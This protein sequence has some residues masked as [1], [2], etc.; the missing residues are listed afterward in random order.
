MLRIKQ[1]GRF[2]GSLNQ[3][4]PG[5]T[6]NDNWMP[7]FATMYNAEKVWN[8]FKRYLKSFIK[9]TSQCSLFQQ[10]EFCCWS[11]HVFFIMSWNSGFPFFLHLNYYYS[12]WVVRAGVSKHVSLRAAYWSAHSIEATDGGQCSEIVNWMHLREV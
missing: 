12:G 10:K 2:V 5:K 6:F 11:C 7:I 1:Y 4:P 3:C 9:D 8:I